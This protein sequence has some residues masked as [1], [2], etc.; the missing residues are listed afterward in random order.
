MRL[1]IIYDLCEGNLALN[2]LQWLIFHETQLNQILCLMYMYKVDL[3]LK[4][5]QWLIFHKTQLNQILCLMYMYKED[6]ALKTFNGWY[7]IKPN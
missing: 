2:T 7:A 1:Q 5:L 4:N 6:L 3:A